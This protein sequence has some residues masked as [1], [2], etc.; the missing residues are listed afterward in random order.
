MGEWYEEREAQVE[1]AHGQPKQKVPRKQRKHLK[2]ANTYRGRINIALDSLKRMFPTKQ[3]V[4]LTPIHRSDFHANDRNWQCDES[5]TNS[6]GLYLDAYVDAVKEAANVWAVPVIDWSA[7]GGLFPMLNEHALYFRDART[8][9]LHPND[10]GHR[11][12][13]QTLMYQ[14][15][16]HNWYLKNKNR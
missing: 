4:L 8:D 11:R 7:S 6:C 14:L 15:F 2:D 16:T 10:L 9:L 13:G 1:Y 3:I 5:Y 12:L